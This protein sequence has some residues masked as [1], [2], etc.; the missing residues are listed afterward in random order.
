MK[1]LG[2]GGFRGSLLGGDGSGTASLEKHH[3]KGKIESGNP[4]K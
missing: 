2:V 1:G 3:H 4:S